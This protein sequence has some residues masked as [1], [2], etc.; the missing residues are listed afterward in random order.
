[1]TNAELTLGQLKTLAG[2]IVHPVFR[3]YRKNCPTDKTIGIYKN[4]I[5]AG[6]IRLIDGD[7]TLRS[8]KFEIGRP[9]DPKLWLKLMNSK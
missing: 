1:M 3:E 8:G 6:P 2:G 7:K 9:P 5:F 4:D